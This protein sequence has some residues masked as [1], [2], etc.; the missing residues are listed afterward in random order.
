M[1]QF[2]MNVLH[3]HIRFASWF[4][5]LRTIFIYTPREEFIKEA[6]EYIAA[7]RLGGD[8]LEFG[9]FKGR[10]FVPA[11]HFAQRNNLKGMRF[12]GFD[13]FEGL[14][15]IK[16]K[17]EGGEFLEGQYCLSFEQFTKLISKRG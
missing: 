6:M 10:T 2:L 13:S 8:Y 15:A 4:I 9:V 14:P 16:G 11:Y 7:T 1:F 12:Y 5:T 17:D 3:K